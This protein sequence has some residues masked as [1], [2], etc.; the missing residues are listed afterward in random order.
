MSAKWQ[1]P[2]AAS[3]QARATAAAQPHERLVQ[4]THSATSTRHDRGQVTE[5]P[6]LLSIPAVAHHLGVSVAYAWRLVYRG[7]IE[8]VRIDKRV[9]VRRGA[10]EDFIQVHTLPAA[11][12]EQDECI[13]PDLAEV[14][15]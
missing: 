1:V 3:K 10:L 14:G 8:T 5:P 9:L 13:Y 15:D 2:D 6:M 7:D 4:P 12:R 11:S